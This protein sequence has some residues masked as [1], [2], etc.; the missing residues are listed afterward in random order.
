MLGI[1]LKTL[2]NKLNQY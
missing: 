2:Q 1:S